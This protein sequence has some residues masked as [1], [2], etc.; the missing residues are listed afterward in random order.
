VTAQLV[1]RPC[2][3]CRK[4]T[5]LGDLPLLDNPKAARWATRQWCSACLLAGGH[6]TP[7]ALEAWRRRRV[8]AFARAQADAA[9]SRRRVEYV[10][11]LRARAQADP[12]FAD[13]VREVAGA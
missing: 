13:A 11:Q 4:P 8:E 5:P 2:R 6:I 7:R 1:T 9:A 3:R 10:E 12:V